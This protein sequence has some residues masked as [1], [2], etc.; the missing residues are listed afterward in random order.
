MY[1][2]QIVKKDAATVDVDQRLTLLAN[3]IEVVSTCAFFF[4]LP[5]TLVSEGKLDAHELSFALSM[6]T[7]VCGFDALTVKQKYSGVRTKEYL[8]DVYFAQEIRVTAGLSNLAWPIPV[9]EVGH[10][11]CCLPIAFCNLLQVIS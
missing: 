4:K 8:L 7:R 9:M 5:F 2:W 3:P 6:Q 10:N 11:A 1:V